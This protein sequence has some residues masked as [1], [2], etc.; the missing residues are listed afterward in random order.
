MSYTEHPVRRASDRARAPVQNVSV[1]HGRADVVVA[2]ELLDRPDVVAIF[3]QMGGERVAKRVTAYRFGDTRA[4][5]RRLHRAL[6]NRLVKVMAAALAGQ[7][8][9][10]DA[11][12]RK[13]PLPATSRSA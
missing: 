6:K 7:P 3:Q 8:V 2:K 4:Q 5:G 10:V 11:C 9:D 12:C 13:H 1:D